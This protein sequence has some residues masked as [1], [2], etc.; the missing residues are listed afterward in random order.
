M[1]AQVGGSHIY[2]FLTI[3]ASARTAALGGTFI[4]VKDQDPNC[5]LQNPS[6]LNASMSNKLLFNG[7]LYFDGVTFGDAAYVK[8][9]AKAGTFM[10]N[11]HYADYGSFLASDITGQIQGTFHAADYNFNVG[12]GMQLNPY[13][14][15]GAALKTIYSDLYLYNSFG[16]ATDVAATYYDST[17]KFT[18][19]IV[20]RNMGIQVK[21]YV[22]GQNEPLPAEVDVAVSKKL[23]HT[24]IRFNLTWRHLEQFDLT[25][26]DSYDA[27][28]VDPLTGETTV[29]SYSFFNKVSRHLIIAA[30]IL[31]SQNFHFRA[32]YNF[33]RRQE[34]ALTTAP[35]TAGLCWGFGLKISKFIIGYSRAAYHM[36]GSA[37]HFSISTNLSDFG[38]K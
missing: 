28:E 20:G 19:A 22:E 30:E 34:L 24:P 13:F 11:M 38:A 14:S 33:Q 16:L 32:G 17:A 35:G 29:T 8:D 15:I 6:L 12:W 7:V 3:P 31:F 37:D 36:E 5:A 27:T 4:S 26:V 2:S 18:L 9:F 23:S 25:Y 21:K 10:A 1:R